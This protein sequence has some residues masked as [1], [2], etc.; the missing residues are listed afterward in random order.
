MRRNLCCSVVAAALLT[1]AAPSWMQVST[2]AA[3]GPIISQQEVSPPNSQRQEP[4]SAQD[5]KDE[6]DA[7]FKRLAG[8]WIPKSA[9]LAGDKIPDEVCKNIQL[10]MSPGRYKT[11]TSGVESS[12]TITIDVTKEPRSMDIAIED[13]PEAGKTIKCIYKLESEILHVA[14]SLAFEDV[15]PVDFESNQDNKQLVIVYQRPEKPADESKDSKP[16]PEESDKQ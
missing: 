11:I 1:W 2:I 10:E 8:K 4:K 9:V 12:G 5:A 14:Y 15:R 16:E 7:E 13:G 6:T 3:G